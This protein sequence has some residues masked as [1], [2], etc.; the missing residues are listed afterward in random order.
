MRGDIFDTQAAS[1]G[2]HA[3]SR[4]SIPRLSPR[5]SNLNAITANN[6]A[7]ANCSGR[8]RVSR[9]LLPAEPAMQPAR[10]APSPSAVSEL[11]SLGVATRFPRT[12]ANEAAR[13]TRLL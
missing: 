7:A 2:F 8:G 6:G 5:N 10:H 4:H 9:W 13:D 12:K 1:F 11:E 3:T